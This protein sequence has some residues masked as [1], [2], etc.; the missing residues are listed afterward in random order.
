MVRDCLNY[1]PP[2]VS[3]FFVSIRTDL[4][5]HEPIWDVLLAEFELCCVFSIFHVAAIVQ[6]MKTQYIIV[7]FASV[8]V[9]SVGL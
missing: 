1:L 9:P 7:V 8:F 6:N 3:L 5:M 4:T 2:S